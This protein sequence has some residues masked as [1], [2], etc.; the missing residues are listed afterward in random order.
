MRDGI[1]GSAVGPRP[2]SNVMRWHCDMPTV[3][4]IAL[5]VVVVLSPGCKRSVE[6]KAGAR[7]SAVASGAT[8][9]TER[10]GCKPPEAGSGSGSAP[11]A[12]D[13]PLTGTCDPGLLC[14]SD[15]CVRPPQANCTVVADVL[16][17]KE[18]GNYAP[19][20]QRAPTVAAKQAACVAAH[21]SK[22]EAKCLGQA[23]DKWAQAQCVPRMFPEI[24]SGKGT[25]AECGILIDKMRATMNQEFG[26]GSD[27]QSQKMV[28]AAITAIRTSCMEDG[29]PTAFKKCIGDSS[30]S[31][32]QNAMR[33]CEKEMPPGPKEKLMARMES[34]LRD[35]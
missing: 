35:K 4:L 21:V 24:A 20:E 2:A 1:P 30:S 23:R 26:Q 5:A 31:T 19:A 10:A 13:D 9:G 14:L 15:L 27:P 22:D 16:A 25:T 32:D 17:S 29:W 12:S 33:G 28:G 6:D 8:L 11:T 7:G 3:K 34:V 18:L